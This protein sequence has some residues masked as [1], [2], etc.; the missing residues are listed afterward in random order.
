LKGRKTRQESAPPAAASRGS[1]L[2]WPGADWPTTARS[3]VSRAAPPPPPRGGPGFAI[4]DLAEREARDY[5][6]R[7]RGDRR[8]P[9]VCRRLAPGAPFG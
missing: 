1:G 8:A 9:S 5:R 4:G 7:P 2:R 6:R 3:V